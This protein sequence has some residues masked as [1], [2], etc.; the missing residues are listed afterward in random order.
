MNLFVALL[1]GINVSG[2]NII[3]MI[4][5]KQSLSSLGYQNIQTYIQSGN[6]IFES[7]SKDISKFENQIQRQI[8]K[9]F[10]HTV[11]V[12]VFSK[13]YFLEVFHNNPLIKNNDL[14]TKKLNVTFLNTSPDKK[15]L[16]D[17]TQTFP[18]KIILNDKILYIYYPNG[19]GRSKLNSSFI[20][21]KLK[22]VSTSRNWNTVTKLSQI[23]EE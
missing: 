2:H 20:E 6:V 13:E 21:R 12:M 16:E 10:G 23:L 17:L 11:F 4:D 18:E 8:Q 7:K 19:G 9:D 15:L 14:D 5:L 1:R 22:V 3:K